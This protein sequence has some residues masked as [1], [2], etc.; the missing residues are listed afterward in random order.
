MSSPDVL[1]AGRA[2]A[3]DLGPQDVGEPA[4]KGLAGVDGRPRS[5]PDGA[6]GQRLVQVGRQAAV[7][8][9]LRVAAQ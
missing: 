2:V 6:P 7:E 1:A 8:G 3:R 5:Q 9:T 4:V